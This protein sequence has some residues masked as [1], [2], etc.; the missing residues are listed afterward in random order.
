M[1]L[2][3]IVLTGVRSGEA[4]EATWDEIYLDNATWT[5][6]ASRMK[7]GREHKV[8]LSKQAMQ[9]LAHAR[10]TTPTKATTESSPPN[11]GAGISGA[12]GSPSS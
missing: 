6:P 8:P 7:N 4:S 12:T 1:L 10:L 9:I 3:F 11:A 2:L 5:I